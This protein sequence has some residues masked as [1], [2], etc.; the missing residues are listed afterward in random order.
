M[1]RSTCFG[2][3]LSQINH[4]NTCSPHTNWPVS[5]LQYGT[6]GHFRNNSVLSPVF[7]ANF[8]IFISHPTFF[9]V[10]LKR[11]ECPTD[12]VGTTLY[13]WIRRLSVPEDGSL[14]RLSVF[15]FIVMTSHQMVRAWFSGKPKYRKGV[16]FLCKDSAHQIPGSV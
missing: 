6:S 10:P 9:V 15:E 14:L 12:L 3:F 5:S 2:F 16:V 1:H 13:A 11:I 4:S 7:P 8:H